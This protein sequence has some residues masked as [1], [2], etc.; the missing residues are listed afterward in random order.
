MA[1]R[2]SLKSISGN[3]TSIHTWEIRPTHLGERSPS[4]VHDGDLD[5]ILRRV[6]ESR[7]VVL[8]GPLENPNSGQRE[9]WV[10]GPEGY[11]VVASG[12]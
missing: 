10:S 4:L 3:S 9:I 11:V 2:S 5:S 12:R 7:S 6:R 8:D 1:P